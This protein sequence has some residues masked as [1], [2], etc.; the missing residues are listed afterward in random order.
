M[1][2]PETMATLDNTRQR[3][4]KRQRKPKAQMLERTERQSRI[5]ISETKATH[6]RENRKVVKNGHSRDKGNTCQ[7]EPKGSQEWTFQG[8]RQHRT[9]KTERRQPKQIL[10]STNSTD[11]QHEPHKKPKQN[12]TKKTKNNTTNNKKQQQKQVG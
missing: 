11:E 4:N 8:Q 12:R 2:N 1:D 10:N 7:R 6:V 3:T 9:Q 5:D